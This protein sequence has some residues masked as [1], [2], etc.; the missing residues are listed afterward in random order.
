MYIYGRFFFT[1][2]AM[3][4]KGHMKVEASNNYRKQDNSSNQGEVFD[5]ND[6]FLWIF[7]SAFY[8]FDVKKSRG[9]DCSQPGSFNQLSQYRVV[10]N[11][12]NL[13]EF[14]SNPA[15][16][17]FQG[18]TAKV[19]PISPVRWF[20]SPWAF[21]F[22]TT[23]F[24]PSHLWELFCVRRIRRSQPSFWLPWVLIFKLFRAVVKGQIGLV[25]REKYD[26]CAVASSYGSR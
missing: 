20:W 25:F 22:S 17:S 24:S 13:Y 21:S 15:S 26:P 3:S 6:A 4:S 1:S 18:P 19:S 7:W 8:R 11:T 14:P 16:H 9:G 12:F 5:K 2:V 10:S 23:T